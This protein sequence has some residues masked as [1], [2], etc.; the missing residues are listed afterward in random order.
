MTAVPPNRPL[1]WRF[2]G[3]SYVWKWPNPEVVEW[4]LSDTPR[5]GAGRSRW[6][7]DDPRGNAQY[8][9]RLANGGPLLSVGSVDI[10]MS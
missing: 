9:P 10:L 7:K 2:F 6:L 8:A 4:P 5:V 3:R 1:A